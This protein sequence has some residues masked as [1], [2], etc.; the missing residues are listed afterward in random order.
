[1]EYDLNI[2]G[3]FGSKQELLDVVRERKMCYDFDPYYISD[4][5]GS[6]VQIGFQMNLYGTFPEKAPDTT[7]DSPEYG[8][9]EGDVLR[10]AEAL[11]NTCD[12]IHMCE[13]T[14]IE[15]STITYSPDRKM[16]PDVTVRIPIFDRKNFG[17]PVDDAIRF[18]LETAIKLLESAGLR[19]TR[20]G[21]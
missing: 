1:M 13:S 16:R 2:T 7:P 14:T 3:L 10:V 12:P 17:H 5:K 11:S 21:D 15:P 4:K 19:K 8:D 6:L 20:W 9:V 18:T